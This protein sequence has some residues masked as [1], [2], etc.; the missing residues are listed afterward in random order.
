MELKQ[1][2]EGEEKTIGWLLIVPY[3]IETR[4]CGVCYQHEQYF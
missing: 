3:G 1:T 2:S 4:R